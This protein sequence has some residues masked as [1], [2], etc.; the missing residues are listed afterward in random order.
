[1][2][3]KWKSISL[4][5]LSLFCLLSVP[6]SSI[7]WLV[8]KTTNANGYATAL[9]NLLNFEDLKLDPRFR[10][11]W[12]N[13]LEGSQSYASAYDWNYKVNLN[14]I[15]NR[16]IDGNMDY[17]NAS[18]E[19]KKPLKYKSELIDDIYLGLQV[20]GHNSPCASELNEIGRYEISNFT[21][22][23]NA[24][25]TLYINKEDPNSLLNILNIDDSE[26]RNYQNKEYYKLINF[27]NTDNIFYK[28]SSKVNK[29]T[30]T[31]WNNQNITLKL[32]A[33]KDSD[34]RVLSIYDPKYHRSSLGI[35]IITHT[36]NE[37]I[38][39]KLWDWNQYNFNDENL[40]CYIA[41]NLIKFYV[42]I[43]LNYI[44]FIDP[45][46]SMYNVKAYPLEGIDNVF[47]HK[48]GGGGG[49][50]PGSLLYYAYKYGSFYDL[51]I[52]ALTYST[53]DLRY[54]Y[55]S[56][57]QNNIIEFDKNNKDNVVVDDIDKVTNNYNNRT[58]LGFN[59]WIEFND[60][61]RGFVQKTW[62]LL[63]FAMDKML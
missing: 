33:K 58:K 27:N 8:K 20:M 24:G 11:N 46:S 49:A 59:P 29:D 21:A 13:L 18:F 53:T 42:E 15:M 25:Y 6:I 55:I 37:F 57:D 63:L 60:Q 39:Y 9:S 41:S 34:S 16:V 10:A 2:K 62:N 14:N 19:Q 56:Y 44:D 7:I 22:L 40:L 3:K 30:I 47:S 38:Q 17:I 4:M 52:I 31:K 35:R 48:E 1:M 12:Y 43:G 54:I 26:K 32:I 45:N 61:V 51:R 23:E 36:S 28:T 5:I 50:T